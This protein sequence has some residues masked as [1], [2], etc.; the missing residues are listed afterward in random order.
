MPL[1]ACCA[2]SAKTRSAIPIPIRSETL[3]MFTHTESARKEVV[4]INK[5]VELTRGAEK[6]LANVQA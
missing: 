4:R 1:I 5:I 2:A 3:E 6:P